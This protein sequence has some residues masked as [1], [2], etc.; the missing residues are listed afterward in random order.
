MRIA[1]AIFCSVMLLV[2]P[3]LAQDNSAIR[4]GVIN[5]QTLG[6]DLG[7]DGDIGFVLDSEVAA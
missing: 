4:I 7:H 5:D 1:S 2:T 3:T 6:V